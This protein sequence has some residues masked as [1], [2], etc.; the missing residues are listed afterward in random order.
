MICP[1]M[2]ASEK[3]LAEGIAAGAVPFGQVT[4]TGRF[5]PKVEEQVEESMKKN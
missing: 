1:K 5:S 2:P 3:D 4:D